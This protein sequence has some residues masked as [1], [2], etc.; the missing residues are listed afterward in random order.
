MR[1]GP[2]LNLVVGFNGS[3][4]SSIVAAVGLGLAGKTSSMGQNITMITL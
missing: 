1:P 3:G 2:A 4:K